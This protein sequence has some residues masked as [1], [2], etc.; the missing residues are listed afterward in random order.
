MRS[1]RW[2]GPVRGRRIV[3]SVYVFLLA[4]MLATA[5]PP[6]ARA[7]PM[8]G[9][10]VTAMKPGVRVS[11]TLPRRAYPYQALVRVMVRI[12]NLSR[13][14][15]LVNNGPPGCPPISPF[16]AVWK[17]GQ[18]VVSANGVSPIVLA[19]PRC[20]PPAG[21]VGRQPVPGA[22]L[23]G[24]HIYPGGHFDM[25]FY[26]VLGGWRLRASVPL[27]TISGNTVTANYRMFTPFAHVRFTR[28]IPPAVQLCPEFACATITPPVGTH[29]RG[30][31]FFASD[32]ATGT[33]PRPIRCMQDLQP[34]PVRGRVVRPDCAHPTI[35]HF[36]A[37]WLNHRVVEVS[38]RR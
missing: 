20:I 10:T 24:T 15:V 21:G 38:L 1:S 19:G 35:W 36:M 7:Q 9:E 29:P 22:Q 25:Y 5:F 31:L 13:G 6:A 16:I 18:H 14:L 8:P 12:E 2:M 28:G 37:G 17:R 11:L 26:V 4:S 33:S 23:P 32:D 27:S 3:I 30:P 34:H